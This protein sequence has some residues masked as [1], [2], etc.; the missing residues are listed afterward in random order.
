MLKK[1]LLSAAIAM[2]VATG[3]QAADVSEEIIQQ[4]FYPYANGAPTFEGLQAG[5]TI[6]QGNV[7]QFKDVLDPGMYRFIK[8]GD[9]EIKV[10]AT[11]SFDLHPSYVE[12]TRKYSGDVA[13]GAGHGEIS[14]T[15]AGRPFPAEPSTDDPRAGEKLAWNYKY[16]YNWGDSAA[17]AP[18]YW[19]MRDMESG[20]KERVLKFNFHFLNFTHRTSQ[21]P[22]PKIE[23]NPSELFRGIYA[24]VLEPFDVKNTQLLIHRFEDDTKVDNAYLYLGF[25]RRVRR[26]SS[27]QT[28]DAFLGT[29]V[30]I[31]DFEGYNGR[32]SDMKWNYQGTRYMLM[33]FFN[34]NELALDA[35]TH[36]DDDGY[37]VVAFGGKGGCFPNITWQLRKV[38]EVDSVPVDENHPISKRTHFMDA[39]TFTIPRTVVYDRKGDMWKNWVIGQAHPDHHLPVNKGTGVSI[40]DAFTMIDIQANHCTTGQFKGIV[41][42]EMS[43]VDKFSVQNMRASGN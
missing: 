38:Y 24:Q 2:T 1:T 11:T 9:T 13:L 4:S 34:H 8:N 37:Q 18:F 41:D 6:N 12:A 25:Q 35:E 3:A 23:P 22:Y 27:G 28:T 19:T 39:Q 17:I 32:I 20:K 29:D 36:Q 15:V 31:E 26:L 10:G 33:P 7:E 43:P 16:G 5:M 14:P 30:M 21:E 42:P 40:D